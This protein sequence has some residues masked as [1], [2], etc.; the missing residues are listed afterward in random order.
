[1]IGRQLAVLSRNT[2]QTYW[3]P[4]SQP[5]IW[6]K[7]PKIGG[8]WTLRNL[9]FWMYALMYHFV[10]V[11]LSFCRVVIHGVLFYQFVFIIILGCKYN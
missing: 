11:F 9:A 5:N 1:M 8:V 3:I 4:R 6:R 10:F 2:V 7:I